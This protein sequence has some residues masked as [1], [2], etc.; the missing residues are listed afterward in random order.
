MTAR[1]QS[2]LRK[3]NIK[4]I[5]GSVEKNLAVEKKNMSTLTKEY[6]TRQTLKS[7]MANRPMGN[8]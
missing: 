3:K 6:E 5:I 1:R 4:I 7:F 8:Y 2:Q